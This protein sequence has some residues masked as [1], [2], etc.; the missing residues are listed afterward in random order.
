MTSLLVM[1]YI[2]LSLVTLPLVLTFDPNMQQIQSKDTLFYVSENTKP[3]TVV[4]VIPDSLD[5]T[6]KPFT[7]KKREGS[8]YFEVTSFGEVILA[9]PIDFEVTNREEFVV[10]VYNNG[11]GAK[12]QE[13]FVTVTADVFDENEAAPVFLNDKDEFLFE[14]IPEIGHLITTVSATDKD[15]A[16]VG[17]LQF[18]VDSEFF[19]INRTSG[20]LRVAK[21]LLPAR[22]SSTSDSSRYDSSAPSSGGGGGTGGASLPPMS[23]YSLVVTVSDGRFERKKK[24]TVRVRTP[25]AQSFRISAEAPHTQPPNIKTYT[26]SSQN[27]LDQLINMQSPELIIIAVFVIAFFLVVILAFIVFSIFFTRTPNPQGPHRAAPTTVLGGAPNRYGGH[28]THPGAGMQGMNTVG[29][30]V[31][32][33]AGHPVMQSPHLGATPTNSQNIMQSLYIYGD[34][35]TLNNN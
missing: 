22:S 14:E 2:I 5:W 21:N 18:F 20:E 32:Y 13:Y 26:M 7:Y 23:A 11:T 28:G 17:K 24:F 10:N 30:R 29:S 31:Y 27:G 6:K 15:T 1:D 16:D 25:T 35:G 33:T 3:S 4:Y 19:K 34:R 8:A 9:K 12:V